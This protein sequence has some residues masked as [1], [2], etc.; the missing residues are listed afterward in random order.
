MKVRHLRSA[1]YGGDI[2]LPGS[3]CDDYPDEVAERTIREGIAELVEEPAGPPVEVPPVVVPPVGQPNPVEPEG[4]TR[5][6]REAQLRQMY[7]QS[8]GWREVAKIAELHGITEKPDGGW[9]EAIPAILD[10]E[11]P[12]VNA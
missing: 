8:N 11:F 6:A 4:R 7:A 3:I 2:F 1:T 12:L 10:L 5:E 9:D